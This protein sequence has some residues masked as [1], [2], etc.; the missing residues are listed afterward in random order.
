MKKWKK[1][2]SKIA[3]D[4]KWFKVRQDKVKLPDGKIIDD[5]YVWLEGDLSLIVP[6]TK[7]K[8]II[9][10]K[11]YKHASGQIM[12]EYPA[13]YVDEGETPE[14]AAKRELLEETGFSSSKF[15]LLGKL[16]N[17]PTKTV[18]N[19]YLYLAEDVEEV[20]KKG[21]VHSEDT[22]E[23]ELLILP[24]KEVLKMVESGEI[25]VTSSVAATYLASKK[26]SFT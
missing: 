23:I 10:V 3:F 11:Q 6:V 12:I 15:T 26:I 21:E 16:T 8:Q 1:L 14:Q 20:A 9:L 25:W 4:N 5:Y 24:P 19:I 2:D 7:G 18:G 22:E 13:G 17:N